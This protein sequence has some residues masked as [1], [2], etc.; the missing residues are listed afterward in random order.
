M[1]CSVFVR[2]GDASCYMTD[3]HRAVFRPLFCVLWTAGPGRGAKGDVDHKELL[4]QGYGQRVPA[5][6]HHYAGE[7]LQV[8]DL[9][10]RPEASYLLVIPASVEQCGLSRH[11]RSN[12][13]YLFVGY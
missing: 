7:P 2:S 13:K 11:I 8:W 6:L 12:S 9:G 4:P 1:G 5:S 3:T 10:L